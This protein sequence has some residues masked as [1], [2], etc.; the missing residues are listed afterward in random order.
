MTRSLSCCFLRNHCPIC[1]AKCLKG[2]SHPRNTRISLVAEMCIARSAVVVMCWGQNTSRK[3]LLQWREDVQC[4]VRGWARIQSGHRL[5]F[6]LEKNPHLLSL[7]TWIPIFQTFVL[8]Y[9]KRLNLLPNIFVS[10]LLEGIELIS[11]HDRFSTPIVFLVQPL[12]L[13]LFIVTCRARV[14]EGILSA[15]RMS[16]SLGGW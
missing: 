5:C 10:T 8:V 12:V 14:A 6:F 11:R 7:G 2:G 9:L 16:Q 13:A 4:R 3:F 15:E 1:W